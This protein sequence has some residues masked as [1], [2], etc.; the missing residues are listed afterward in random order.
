MDVGIR[1]RI[2]HTEWSLFGGHLIW[3]GRQ[4]G[5]DVH[6]LHDD[7]ETIRRRQLRIYRV[8]TI[9]VGVGAW[10]LRLTWRPGD[11][12]VGIDAQSGGRSDERVTGSRRVNVGFGCRIGSKSPY[13]IWEIRKFG[14][15]QSNTPSQIRLR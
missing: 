3:N 7:V 13:F 5:R 15:S 10:T 8:K 12:F 14:E 9:R 11:H 4:N 6:F 2:R 1:C